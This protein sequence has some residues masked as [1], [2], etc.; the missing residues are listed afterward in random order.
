[1]DILTLKSAFQ[2]LWP[3]LLAGTL[4]YSA[5]RLAGAFAKSAVPSNLPA[6]LLTVCV[7]GCT[8]GV[9]A[10]N[11]RSPVTEG[12]IT[13][14]TGL[15]TAF[16][17]YLVGRGRRQ[18]LLVSRVTASSICIFLLA[19]IFGL[20]AGSAN[21][22][23]YENFERAYERRLLYY[24]NVQL[25]AC[26]EARKIEIAAIA[27]AASAAIAATPLSASS[28]TAPARF[29]SSPGEIFCQGL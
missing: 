6:L 21:R 16:A 27:A 2:S 14:G 20:S 17:A 13:G 4:A 28:A 23:Q 19:L 22:R 10:G 3:V 11:S 24:T 15:L 9:I 12:V 18:S 5:G 7:A 29:A 26:L 1:V 25:P 8:L